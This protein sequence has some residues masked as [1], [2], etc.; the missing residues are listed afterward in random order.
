M[1]CSVVF[2]LLAGCTG[3][4]TVHLL[5]FMRTN[6]SPTEAL[7]QTIKVNEAYY[8]CDDDGKLSVAF[9][10]RVRSLLG[11]AL[12]V[13]WLMS[14]VLDGMPAGSEKLYQL[15]RPAVRISQSYGGDHRRC[16]SLR[17]IAVIYVSR[18]A[19]LKGRFQIT[20]HQQKFSVLKGWMSA[21]PLIVIGEFEAVENPAAGKEILS[22]TEADGFARDPD[23]EPAIRWIRKSQADSQ[24][25]TQPATNKLGIEN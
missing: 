9:R 15:H 13:E 14:M 16:R 23:S 17:G 11:K 24:P 25:A 19:P 6:F 1:S 5:P 20:V 12:D 10:Y 7:I 22:L 18:G 3:R 8:W 2:L 4:A 21:S